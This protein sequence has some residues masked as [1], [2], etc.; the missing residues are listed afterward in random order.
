MVA[1]RFIG[2]FDVNIEPPPFKVAF[3]ARAAGPRG[4][5]I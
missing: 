5:D 3:R 2:N 4:R 1:E